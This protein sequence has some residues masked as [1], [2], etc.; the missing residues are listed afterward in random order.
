VQRTALSRPA[1][2]FYRWQE[3]WS[4][5]ADPAYRT[6]PFDSLKYI[7]LSDDDPKRYL[8]FGITLRERYEYNDAL[9]SASPGLPNET[10]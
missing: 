3:D 2:G 9:D 4:V 1:I 7:S 6:E 8:S 10:T 5:L